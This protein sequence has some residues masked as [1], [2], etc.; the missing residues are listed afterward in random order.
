MPS[1]EGEQGSDRS[2]AADTGLHSEFGT[3]VL[4]DEGRVLEWQAEPI[5]G[6]APRQCVGLPLAGLLVSEDNLS[7]AE[8]ARL[9]AVLGLDAGNATVSLEVNGGQS[10]MPVPVVLHLT[11]VGQQESAVRVVLVE[12]RAGD[13]AEQQMRIARE[14]VAALRQLTGAIGH[15]LSNP[16]SFILNFGELNAEVA[17]EIHEA[18]RA[19]RDDPSTAREQSI[20]D[21]VEDLVESTQIAMQHTKR[22]EIIVKSLLGYMEAYGERRL[23]TDINVLVASALDDMAPSTEA[24]VQRQLDPRPLLAAVDPAGIRH[25]IAA[26]LK[27]AIDAV[28]ERDPSRD[29]EPTLVVS[30]HLR[31]R[32][33][34]ICVRDNGRGMAPEERARVLEPFFTTRAGSEGAGL[35]LTVTEE[36]IRSHGGRL[37]IESRGG[38]GTTVS[39]TVPATA[40]F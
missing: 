33:V 34:E 40:R 21:L 17:Q 29:G 36:I 13:P 30:T 23:V 31:G 37:E 26:V 11:T 7:T 35:G 22:I 8:A 39:M 2:A 5:L 20:T 6:A 32:E 25:A 3:I 4:D 27:N 14:R 16:L 28:A 24:S 19:Y 9:Q 15:E 1:L 18:L 38:V 10:E 12:R